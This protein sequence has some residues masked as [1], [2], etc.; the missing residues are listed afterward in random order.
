M[1]RSLV[2]TLIFLACTCNALAS[3]VDLSWVKDV[4]KTIDANKQKSREQAFDI[5][6][7][8]SGDKSN[9]PKKVCGASVANLE[10]KG[11][12]DRYP[13][14]LV[15]VSFSMPMEALKTL[16]QQVS[17]AGGKLVFRG[18]VNSSFPKTAEKMKELGV[19]ALIDPTLFEAYQIKVCPVF[20][21]TEKPISSLEE[22]PSFDQLSGHVS[23]FHALETF[24]KNGNLKAKA[25]IQ[26]LKGVSR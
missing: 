16:G 20:V 9:Q 17:K 23:L 7:G 25:L 5:V 14:L 10:E 3:D 6:Q 15:F 4:M 18:F 22:K 24:A 19:D 13:S 1:L 8:T 12:Q 21:M 11:R 2:Y 26:D